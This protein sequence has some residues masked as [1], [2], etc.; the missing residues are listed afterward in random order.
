MGEGGGAIRWGAALGADL[1]AGEDRPELTGGH[2]PDVDGVHAVGQEEDFEA[3][4]QK[5]LRT[6]ASKVF[7]EDLKEELACDFISPAFKAN[8]SYEGRYL[9]GTAL[10][11]P[12]IA[13]RQI[14][15]AAGPEGYA[16]CA[17]CRIR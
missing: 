15:I 7:I 8:A 10:A 6:G 14:E 3:V 5:A 16:A 17:F 1:A 11:R 13:R 12:L 2:V 9:L 4:R